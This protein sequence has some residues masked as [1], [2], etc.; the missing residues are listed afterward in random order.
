[1]LS[2]A[3][4]ALA[5]GTLCWP[6]GA[7]RGR[8]TELDRRRVQAQLVTTGPGSATQRCLLLVVLAAGLGALLAGMAGLFG[9][10]TMSYREV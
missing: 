1:M 9:A 8:L 2:L 6:A 4:V 7:S 3:L 10:P 5:A